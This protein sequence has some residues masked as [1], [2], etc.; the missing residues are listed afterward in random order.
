M[1]NTLFLLLFISAS[2]FC[3][4]NFPD[5]WIGKWKGN[6]EIMTPNGTVKQTVPMEINIAKLAETKK[7]QWQ[8]IYN[9]KDIRNYEIVEKDAAKGHY[10]LDEKNNIFIDVN[11]FGNK[12]FSNFEVQGTRLFD[13]HEFINDTII[14]ELSSSNTNGVQTSGDGTSA[15]PTV[16]SFPQTAYQKAILYRQK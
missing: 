7:W 13:T 4:V 8:I 9:D 12:L 15:I 1:K 16:K 11:V 2:A 3:Q 14:F 5:G 6:L 10:V